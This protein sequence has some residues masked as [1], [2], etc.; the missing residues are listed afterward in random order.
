[1]LFHLSEDLTDADGFAATGTH[2][3]RAGGLENPLLLNLN[4]SNVSYEKII[5]NNAVRPQT[6]VAWLDKQ[7]NP[8]DGVPLQS[9]TSEY[10]K[11]EKIT[12]KAIVKNF[13]NLVDE[14]EKQR[15]SNSALDG[16][17][18]NISYVLGVYGEQADLIPQLNLLRK[19]FPSTST[20]TPVGRLYVRFRKRI[21]NNNLTIVKEGKLF[22]QL[23]VNP[24]I[25]DS[26]EVPAE[27]WTQGLKPSY[28][29]VGDDVD[30]GG[31]YEAG[32]YSTVHSHNESPAYAG[33]ALFSD[34]G[35]T[36]DQWWVT[37]EEVAAD[38]AVG[39]GEG[40]YNIITSGFIFFD[41]EK[42]A[43]SS[44]L[45]Q[46]LDVAMVEDYFGKEITSERIQ[47][48]KARLTRGPTEESDIDYS[49]DLIDE[50]GYGEIAGDEY[51]QTIH[52]FSMTNN[53]PAECYVARDAQ[54]RT[55]LA[56]WGNKKSYMYPRSFNLA[57]ENGLGGYRLACFEFQ[58]LMGGN[59]NLLSQETDFDTAYD[60]ST[61]GTY[62][63][64]DGNDDPQWQYVFQL[65]LQDYTLD[66]VGELITNYQTNLA[67]FEE[68]KDQAA[69]ICG[70][71]NVDGHFNQFFIDA[72]T[73]EHG[74]DL[75]NA[76]WIMMP[77][78]FCIHSDL[79]FN[80]FNG[81]VDSA[82]EEAKSIS[83]KISPYTGIL[84]E[85]ESFWTRV[86]TLYSENYGGGTST[87]G[88]ATENLMDSSTLVPG[89]SDYFEYYN[90]VYNDI[91][92]IAQLG[93]DVDSWS[94]LVE[95]EMPTWWIYQIYGYGPD[96]AARDSDGTEPLSLL[97]NGV[98][99]PSDP[100]GADDYDA[101]TATTYGYYGWGGGSFD[102]STGDLDY[103]S[104]SIK[105]DVAETMLADIKTWLEAAQALGQPGF[106]SDLE[107]IGTL[108]SISAS[109]WYIYYINEIS[110]AGLTTVPHADNAYAQIMI[111][112]A[113]FFFCTMG[114]YPELTLDGLIEYFGLDAND[115][116]SVTYGETS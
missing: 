81:D 108:D 67:I 103:G 101:D 59:D 55:A 99:D 42:V 92:T 28:Q 105:I 106:R 16:A 110:D 113:G 34:N 72:M 44:S 5:E 58:D 4:T 78:V 14:Y 94:Q 112:L 89:S 73:E 32:V 53:I 90:I 74:S 26:R 111:R 45:S 33:L 83:M 37:V 85:V 107:S 86:E 100:P 39:T 61:L 60:S 102:E 88:G 93:N 50:Y 64:S 11:A 54:S 104:W 77:L 57:S 13:E 115:Y 116:I 56:T 30:L 68:Y 47:Y 70:Y 51:D 95:G 66:I 52:C 41:F 48:V 38:S 21:F 3:D 80:Q 82:I 49:S 62:F 19:T 10:Y 36:T 29:Y 9:M 25:V 31:G 15:E 75:A 79:V 114:V 98:W 17:L 46:V 97:Y 69:E 6:E 43:Q 27:S 22:K 2:L 20:A 23:I 12:H 7:G 109:S 40:R 87:I 35:A 71:N 96:I 1:M 91:P 65:S 8:Y 84:D 63:G 18:T 24:K 76:P